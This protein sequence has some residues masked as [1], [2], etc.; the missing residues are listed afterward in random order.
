[1]S[2]YNRGS[3]RIAVR[4]L[5]P[6]EIRMKFV[7]YWKTRAFNVLSRINQGLQQYLNNPPGQSD[8]VS[9]NPVKYLR[10][11]GATFTNARTCISS[12][13]RESQTNQQQRKHSRRCNNAEFPSQEMSVRR[14]RIHR[15]LAKP[16]GQTFSHLAPRLLTLSSAL[17]QQ[18]YIARHCI[19]EIYRSL[20]FSRND[21]Y[22]DNN[23]RG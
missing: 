6:S 12:G 20:L 9:N 7:I 15:T 3:G 19:A 14:T 8:P 2:P 11:I 17:S 10:D 4:Q 23:R 5:F 1:M 22:D 13:L 18:Q 21:V 16:N